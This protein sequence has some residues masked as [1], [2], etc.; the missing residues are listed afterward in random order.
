MPLFRC[1]CL[2]SSS[3]RHLAVLVAHQRVLFPAINLRSLGAFIPDEVGVTLAKSVATDVLRCCVQPSA[4][5]ESWG[6]PRSTRL[7]EC[8]DQSSLTSRSANDGLDCAG[9]AAALE[10]CQALESRPAEEPQRA[11]GDGL[12][13]LPSVV[14]P[15]KG[16]GPKAAHA[17]T[18][19]YA[20]ALAAPRLDG[21]PTSGE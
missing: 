19:L 2:A 13:P 21:P 6:Q 16:A 1:E 14:P 3:L 7:S 11:D 17:S 15:V 8:S 10:S 12:S 18:E 5:S 9:P 4:D 20:F